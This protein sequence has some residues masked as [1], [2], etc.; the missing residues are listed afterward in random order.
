[1]WNRIAASLSRRTFLQVGAIGVGGLSLAGR[2]LG[3][4]PSVAGKSIIMIYF[5]GG[6]S[7]IDTFDMKPQAPTEIRGEFHAIRSNVP[8]IGTELPAFSATESRTPCR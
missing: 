3:A 1:M 7:H 6:P 8:G 2:V 5:P 4:V